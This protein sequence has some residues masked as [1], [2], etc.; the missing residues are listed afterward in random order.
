MSISISLLAAALGAA[1]PVQAGEAALLTRMKEQDWNGFYRRR[2]ADGLNVFLHPDFVLLNSDGSTEGRADA[3]AYVRENEW[4]GAANRFQYKVTRVQLL[5]PDTAN[6]FGAGTFDGS[7]AKGK[8]RMRYTSSNIFKRD[9]GTWR[10]IFS[11]T[12]D[13]A[14]IREEAK[15]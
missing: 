7:D 14:C 2:D 9:G 1:Q 3:V 8:C 10:P 12:S 13:A 11:H 15:R 4:P 5:S 6:V